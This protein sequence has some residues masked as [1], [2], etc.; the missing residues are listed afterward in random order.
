MSIGCLCDFRKLFDCDD[1]TFAKYVIC[2]MPEISSHIIIHSKCWI[3]DDN[4]AL[5]T[6]GN[7]SDRSYYDSGDLEMGII[8]HE[9]VSEFR[10]TIEANLTNVPLFDYD[11]KFP[12]YNTGTYM[13]DN[14]QQTKD[15]FWYFVDTVSHYIDI[16]TAASFKFSP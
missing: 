9:N 1:N 13:L 15:I 14:I 7:L 4:N 11:F 2:R 10:K 5:Y 12:K 6:I 3:F 16:E 8:I